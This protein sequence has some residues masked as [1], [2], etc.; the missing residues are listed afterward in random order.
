M[1]AMVFG[2]NPRGI[3]GAFALGLTALM[4]DYGCQWFRVRLLQGGGTSLK[5]FTIVGLFLFRLLNIVVFLALGA[6]WLSP[7]ARQL[8]HWTLITMPLWNLLGAVKLSKQL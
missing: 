6:W 7:D 3:S 2:L 4:I 8:F 5:L 1:L